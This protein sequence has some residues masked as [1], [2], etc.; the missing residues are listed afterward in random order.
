MYNERNLQ[1]MA[2]SRTAIFVMNMHWLHNSQVNST[3]KL[4]MVIDLYIIPLSMTL[5]GL[6]PYF[7]PCWEALRFSIK[8]EKQLTGGAFLEYFLLFLNSPFGARDSK[9]TFLFISLNSISLFLDCSTIYLLFS[10]SLRRI[11]FGTILKVTYL[12]KYIVFS[13]SISSVLSSPFSCAI[14][15]YTSRTQVEC[16]SITLSFLAFSGASLLLQVLI[17]TMLTISCLDVTIKLNP[18][19]AR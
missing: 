11:P 3:L 8:Q 1:R 17:T 15:K 16:P 5:I 14:N 2:T 10:I 18:R 19:S 12:L 4:G 6:L 7:T 9:S 13:N